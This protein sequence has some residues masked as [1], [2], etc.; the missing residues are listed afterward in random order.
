MQVKTP[1][2][3]IITFLID[4]MVSEESSTPAATFYLCLFFVKATLELKAT[5]YQALNLYYSGRKLTIM[6]FS[7]Y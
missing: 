7:Y 2:D 3:S 6:I 5:V 1:E 4:R